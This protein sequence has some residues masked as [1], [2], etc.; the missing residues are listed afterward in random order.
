M[1]ERPSLTYEEF[2]VLA[3]LLGIAADE[4]HLQALYNEAAPMYERINLLRSIEDSARR[5][6][7]RSG[8]RR[9]GVDV[10]D[11][12]LTNL[13]VAQLAERIQQQRGVAGGGRGR[14]PPAHRRRGV[15]AQRRHHPPGRPRPPRS[16]DRRGGD[17]GRGVPRP[18]P[19]HPGRPEGPLLDQ[20]RTDHVRLRAGRRLRSAGGFRCGRRA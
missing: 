19:R 2:L 13:T 1:A 16:R 4:D 8:G 7:V 17:H 20:R 14:L 3:Q 10:A 6:P 9:R 15:K 5:A 12:N 11:D 18:L